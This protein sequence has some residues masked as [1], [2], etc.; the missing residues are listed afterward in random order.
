MGHALQEAAN[1]AIIG[2]YLAAARYFVLALSV[3]RLMKAA[4]VAFF[5]TCAGTHVLMVT[6]IHRGDQQVTT[7]AAHPAWI[8]WHVLEALAIWTFLI[9]ARRYTL[10]RDR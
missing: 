3:D 6:A 9:R 2:G 8:V 5:L 4:G 1:V 10:R 7:L